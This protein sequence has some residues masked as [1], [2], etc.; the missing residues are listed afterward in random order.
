MATM[1]SIAERREGKLFERIEELERVF[2]HIHESGEIKGWLSDKCAKCGLDLRD[3]I[4][5][6]Q[7]L[8]RG[9]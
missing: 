5:F 7:K 8:E 3:Q 9:R 2:G 6:R 4:H 1:E